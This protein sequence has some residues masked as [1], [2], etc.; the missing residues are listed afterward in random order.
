MDSRPR[1]SVP[2]RDSGRAAL[3]QEPAVIGRFMSLLRPDALERR[4]A[5]VARRGRGLKTTAAA[6]AAITLAGS[7][8]LTAR[9]AQVFDGTVEGLIAANWLGLGA[10]LALGACWWALVV[11]SHGR[12]LEHTGRKLH[13]RAQLQRRIED[14]P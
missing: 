4:G 7:G 6:A 8:L 3:T 12:R 5:E 1:E 2:Y 11:Y 10:V 9:A 13:H 14:S